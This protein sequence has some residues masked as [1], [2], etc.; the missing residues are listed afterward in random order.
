MGINDK[1]SVKEQYNTSKNLSTRISI[2]DKYST[3]K[4]GFGNWITCHYEIETGMKVLELGCGTGSMWAGKGELI[5]KCSK[6]I[7]SDF[8]EGMLEK[9]K[10]TLS[11]YEGI[12]Y[13]VIDIQDIPY[14]DNTFDIV[15]GNMMLYHVPDLYKGLSEVS[16][17]LKEGGKFYCA[18]YGENGIMEYVYGLF[19]D[20]GVE[21]ST[22]N[23]SFTLQNG[24]E[25][26]SKVFPKVT[27][28]DYVDSLEVTNLDD[29]ADYVYSLTG[30]S[31]LK[32][33]PRETMLNVFK[34][35]SVDGVLRVPKDYGMFVAEKEQNK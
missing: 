26:L 30:M 4:Q 17:V 35:N 27:R 11:E 18:T 24:A 34:E 2:H 32:E 25:K 8:S 22:K 20:H 14:L 31:E 23:T 5:K 3:N 33:I 10:E 1:S 7:L 6:F 29:L 16:R 21:A 12:E 28:Y 15:I 19:A 13:Q 9:T